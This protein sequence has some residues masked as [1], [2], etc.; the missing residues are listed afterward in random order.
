MS[1]SV[2]TKLPIFSITMIENQ[3]MMTP[4][5]EKMQWRKT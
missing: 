2:Q 4:R 3:Y 5:N 1:K